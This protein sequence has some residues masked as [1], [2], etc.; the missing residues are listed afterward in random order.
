MKT[1]SIIIVFCVFLLSVIIAKV[2]LYIGLYHY[3]VYYGQ[4]TET[5]TGLNL[6]LFIS[7]T[8]ILLIISFLSTLLKKASLRKITQNS[9]VISVKAAFL[10]LIFEFIIVFSVT[11]IFNIFNKMLY[12]DII[13]LL[14]ESLLFFSHKIAIWYAAQLKFGSIFII[15]NSAII[16][17]FI[18]IPY[19]FIILFLYNYHYLK[20]NNISMNND[21]NIWKLSAFYS[22]ISPIFIIIFFFIL[23]PFNSFNSDNSTDEN[24]VSLIPSFSSTYL[25]KFID[26]GANVNAISKKWQHY[27]PLMVAVSWRPEFVQFLLESGSKVNAEDANGETALFKAIKMNNEEITELLLKYGADVNK[28]DNNGYKP[29]NIAK[30]NNNHAIVNLLLDKGAK[31]SL[32]AKKDKFDKPKIIVPIN[33][34]TDT[35]K[36]IV[37]FNPKPS[38]RILKTPTNN[39]K[40]IILPSSPEKNLNKGIVTFNPKIN[41]KNDDK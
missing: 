12:G 34:T 5:L 40:M 24:F 6:F 33:P 36:G 32:A 28:S 17:L 3:A 30:E 22:S 31:P 13:Y 16:I 1:N 27:T 38:K 8:Y 10:L 4:I 18:Y 25:V 21:K 7:L 2:S 11:A 35:N 19:H 23:I 26:K 37:T 41:Y 15:F 9:F 29:F 20:Q 39:N 14:I